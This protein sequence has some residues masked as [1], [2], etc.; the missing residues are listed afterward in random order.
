VLSKNVHVAISGVPNTSGIGGFFVALAGTITGSSKPLG[1]TR[2]PLSCT[3]FCVP[4][5]SGNLRGEVTI[6]KRQ[7]K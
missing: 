5:G 2:I 1:N 4:F 3:E 7:I 6:K